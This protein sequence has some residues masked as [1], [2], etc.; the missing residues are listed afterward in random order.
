MS[1]LAE[2]TSIA[3]IQQNTTPAWLVLPFA[4]LL[5]MIATG[6]LLYAR[7]WHKHYPKVALILAGLVGE[8]YLLVLHDFYKP[9]EALMEYIQ[10]ITL[11][12]ALYIA[13]GG[14]FIRINK[15][16]TP[17]TNL[18]LLCAG[19]VLANLIGTTGASML[20]IKPYMRLNKARIRVYHMIFFI[21]MVS[22]VGGALTPIG[23]PP[24]FLGFI[25]GVP[26]FWTLY[27]N[28]LPWLVAL[29]LLSMAFL[30][31]DIRNP[32]TAPASLQDPG[33]SVLH[34][35][36]K[37]NL[38][39][40]TLIITTVF[41]DPHIFSWVPAITTHAGQSFSFLRE[42]ILLGVAGL[43]YQ[44]AS[45]EA[46]A[47]NGFT[48]EPL[49]EVVI[50]FVGIFG[51]MI[52]AL[53]LVSRFAASEAGSA[54]I[55]PNT[56]YWGTGICSSML[57]NAPTYLNFGAACM[58]AQGADITKTTDVLA[59]AAGGVF[60]HSILRLKA[61]TIASVFFGAATYIGNGP[62]FMVKSIAEHEGVHMPSFFGYIFRFVVPFLL[63]VLLIIW[64]LF[65]AFA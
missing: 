52:P 43:S 3:S 19:A 23:D 34:I 48:L 50:I 62:N 32:H 56:L 55:T 18:G 49:K 12:G 15:P 5:C 38:L 57:D 26:F 21:W 22:N 1:Q 24:L 39:W 13:S 27:H 54:L 63:P 36:G 30:A 35:V 53:D 7:F 60:P 17:F 42:I 40:L 14:I 11:I 46:L 41:L 65:F 28:G 2:T 47:T 45:R 10:F 25:K 64:L 37:R 16:G 8:Y 59:Y 6:P 29:G 33:Q 20:L 31:F 51:T 61:L 58:A 44:C 9:I 4:V